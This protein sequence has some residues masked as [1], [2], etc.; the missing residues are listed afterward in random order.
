VGAICQQLIGESSKLAEMSRPS[1]EAQ[2]AQV[3]SMASKRTLTVS[4]KN[5][6]VVRDQERESL[7]KIHTFILQNLMNLSVRGRHAVVD[8]YD[9]LIES[10]E[11][12]V[13]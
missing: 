5:S 10:P 12:C 9:G 2:G 3:N 13:S 7:G 11:L 1:S 4:N 6:K 8:E